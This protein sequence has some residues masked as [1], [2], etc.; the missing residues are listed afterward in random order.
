MGATGT[1]IPSPALTALLDGMAD[2]LMSEAEV[3]TGWRP[4]VSSG[5][6]ESRLY[7]FPGPRTATARTVMHGGGQVL[8]LDA[9]LLTFAATDP[10]VMLDA[11]GN[12]ARVFTP[13]VDVL[14]MPYNSSFALRLHFRR[15]VTG[16]DG[17]LRVRGS[18]GRFGAAGVPQDVVNAVRQMAAAR[19]TAARMTAALGE[20]LT[21]WA[22]GDISEKYDA[23]AAASALAVAEAQFAG[24]MTRYRRM[25]VA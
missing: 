25:V 8:E 4:L 14:K 17:R 2:A 3:L 18:W 24:A 1:T 15:P 5:L 20:G 6:D 23:G 13:E 9:P 10:V 22:E 12:V 7:D 21:A 11:A 16:M 19:A